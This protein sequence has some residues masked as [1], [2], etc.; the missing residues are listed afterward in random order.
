MYNHKD[1]YDQIFKV[2]WFVDLW[3]V[4]ELLENE[5]YNFLSKLWAYYRKFFLYFL[6]VGYIND[7]VKD[8][9]TNTFFDNLNCNVQCHY[10]FFDLYFTFLENNMRILKADY[11]EVSDIFLIKIALVR[12][13]YLG[14]LVKPFS[15]SHFDLVLLF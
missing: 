12:F 1:V 14:Q 6:G 13:D 8:I 10:I 15:I 5:I 7:I 4:E 3:I 9:I 2:F 11:N